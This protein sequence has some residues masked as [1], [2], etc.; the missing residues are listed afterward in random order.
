MGKDLEKIANFISQEV[1]IAQ[2]WSCCGFAGD[3][4]LLH[5]ELTKSATRKESE[6]FM[7]RYNEMNKQSKQSSQSKNDDNNN[8]TIL[9]DLVKCNGIISQLLLSLKYLNQSVEPDKII[10]QIDHTF[11][12]T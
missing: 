1:V 12:S 6:E 11:K 8:K 3:R 4:G 2:D 7:R 9:N 5:P 10:K